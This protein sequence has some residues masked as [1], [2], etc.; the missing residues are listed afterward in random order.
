M[1]PVHGDRWQQTAAQA[2]QALAAAEQREREAAAAAQA[3]ASASFTAEA[4][5]DELTSAVRQL[6]VITL[7]LTYTLIVQSRCSRLQSCMLFTCLF[8]QHN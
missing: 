1:I 2:E 5:A 6:Q 8:M 4:Q 3:A 7:L